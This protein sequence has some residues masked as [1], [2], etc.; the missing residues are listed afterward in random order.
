[1]TE[2]V[3]VVGENTPT[4]PAGEAQLSMVKAAMQTL[5]AFDNADATFDTSLPATTS[6]EPGLL[7]PVSS[8]IILG[9][10]LRKDHL[11]DAELISIGFVVRGG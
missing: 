8:G 5:P 9:T 11:F 4:D 7:F 6:S 10:A 3:E 1:M 2:L